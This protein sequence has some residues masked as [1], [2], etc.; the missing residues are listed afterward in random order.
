MVIFYGVA[1]NKILTWQML[2]CD[3]YNARL[4]AYNFIGSTASIKNA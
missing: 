2:R 1:F 3:T 4:H